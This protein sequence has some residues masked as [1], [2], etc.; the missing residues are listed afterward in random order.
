M[1]IGPT[2]RKIRQ[3]KGIQQTELAATLEY[4]PGNLSKIENGKQGYS[5]DFLNR[6]PKALGVPLSAIFKEAEDSSSNGRVSVEEPE[7]L[8]MSDETKKIMTA[9]NRLPKDAK[10]AVKQLIFSLGGNKK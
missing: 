9:L 1:H 8:Y 2:I 6:L 4:D 5:D 7:T 3:R 10:I